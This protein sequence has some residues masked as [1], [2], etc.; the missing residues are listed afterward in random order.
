MNHFWNWGRCISKTPSEKRSHTKAHS[1]KSISHAVEFNKPFSSRVFH[2]SPSLL[3]PI[4]LKL[5]Y[6]V[7]T[8][9]YQPRDL[10]RSAL[11]A[12]FTLQS[13][14]GQYTSVCNL[15]LWG[16]KVFLQREQR[17]TGPG[18]TGRLE[19]FKQRL[20]L[21]HECSGFPQRPSK[22]LWRSTEAVGK[23]ALLI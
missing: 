22:T 8:V 1:W 15:A 10:A 9:F 20:M 13:L 4:V 18:L 12:V 21:G 2:S 5:L 11:W 7:Y 16:G 23:P 17:R 14:P 3:H 19:V 6:G